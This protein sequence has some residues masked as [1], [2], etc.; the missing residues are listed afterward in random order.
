M[1]DITAQ[2]VINIAKNVLIISE[3]IKSATIGYT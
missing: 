2:T 3:W 1:E